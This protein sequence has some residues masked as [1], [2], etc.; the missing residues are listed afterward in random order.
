MHLGSISSYISGIILCMVKFA[1]PTYASYKALKS[2]EAGDD[3]TWL[4][5]WVVIGL[6]TFIESYLIP[7]I[8]ILPLFTV[9]RLVIY[10]WLQLPVFNL[11]VLLFKLVVCPFFDQNTDFFEKVT[12][13][14]KKDLKDTIKNVKTSIGKV[15]KEIL[16]SLENEKQRA[17]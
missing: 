14:N 5:Y 12:I 10:V 17:S 9:I 3:T 1:Y 4:V 8:C 15:Y 16:K 2:P 6:C 13:R 7:F 11:S